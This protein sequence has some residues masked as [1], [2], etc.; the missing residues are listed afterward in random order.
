MRR[1]ANSNCIICGVTLSVHERARGLTCAQPACQQQHLR[2]RLQAEYEFE[3]RCLEQAERRQLR[4]LAERH[5]E[6]REPAPVVLLPVNEK[7]L[8][9]LPEKRIRRFRDYLMQSISRAAA[10]CYGPPSDAAADAAGA[11]SESGEL[12]EMNDR[13]AGADVPKKDEALLRVLGQ[14]CATCR[15]NCCALGAE[16]AFL[17][18]EELLRYM[19]RNPTSRPR[20]VLA[21]YLERLE[22]VSYVDSCVYHGPEGCRLPREMRSSTCNDYLCESLVEIQ[23]TIEWT[24]SPRAFAVAAGKQG[25]VRFADLDDT[26]REEFEAETCTDATP[27]G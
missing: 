20:D 18:P 17:R 13:D 23:T 2:N 10:L 7:R 27:S 16:H 15:G 11:P 14:A 26:G 21:A 9:N 1:F 25:A 24:G 4:V 19:R 12:R 6:A 5:G 22:P 3:Q 8:G